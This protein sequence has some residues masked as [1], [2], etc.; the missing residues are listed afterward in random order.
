MTTQ[1]NGTRLQNEALAVRPLTA[2]VRSE[3]DQTKAYTVTLPYCPCP[4]FFY[5]RGNL[6]SWACKHL[7]AAMGLVGSPSRDTSRLD[8]ATAVEL[9]TDF[10]ANPRMAAAALAR[11]QRMTQGTIDVPGRGIAVIE[12]NRTADTYDVRLPA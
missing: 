8:E 10:G 2:E 12:Y 7:R 3:T 1:T 4:D 11:S 6:E 9:L 5:R